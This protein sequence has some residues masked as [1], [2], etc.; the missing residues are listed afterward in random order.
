MFVFWISYS[1]NTFPQKHLSFLFGARI[2]AIHKYFLLAIIFYFS[3]SIHKILL[4]NVKKP[5]RSCSIVFPWRRF[6]LIFFS[7]NPGD[8][9]FP[10]LHIRFSSIYSTIGWAFIDGILALGDNG[11]NAFLIEWMDP[12]ALKQ[13]KEET[14]GMSQEVLRWFTAHLGMSHVLG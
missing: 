5:L 9:S 12:A 3:Y 13:L 14:T 8:C 2:I 4:S 1:L 10:C 11:N 6:S 7:H